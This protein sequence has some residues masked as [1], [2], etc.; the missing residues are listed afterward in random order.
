[1]FGTKLR[2]SVLVASAMLLAACG[3]GTKD[4]S[5]T[6]AAEAVDTTVPVIVE[7]VKI[8]A[9]F[10]LT[11]PFAV[12]GTSELEGAKAA[13]D[14][15]N[16]NGGILGRPIE[17]LIEDTGSDPQQAATAAAKL[18]KEGVVTIIGP[19]AG[20]VSLPIVP[21]AREANIPFISASGG[22]LP[23]V[24]AL[25]DLR[26]TFVCS[27]HTNKALASFFPYWLDKGFDTVALVGSKDPSFD[28]VVAFMEA[29]GK[30]VGIKIVVESFPRG[31]VDVTVNVVNA[32]SKGADVIF[33]P[34][35]G[36][37][38]ASVLLAAVSLG[39]EAEV[40]THGGN[41]SKGFI[42]LVGEAAFSKA[43]VSGFWSM[44]PNDA[45][46][47]NLDAI[48]RYR[49]DIEAAGQTFDSGSLAILGWDCIQMVV[50]AVEQAGGDTAKFRDA[51]ETL[52]YDGAAASWRNSADNHE[53]VEPGYAPLLSRA[54]GDWVFIRSGATR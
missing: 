48:A 40:S 39:V 2:I 50:A 15:I 21:V 25:E 30:E 43:V 33:T 5:P 35:V 41:V 52:S 22:F 23:L 11:G 38:G 14:A 46:Q 17:L 6:T 27:P 53:G 18:F 19:E 47:A 42:G 13:V 24:T 26:N 28:S 9:L 49:A 54:K 1:M 31:Q 20:P 45:P 4:S 16:A 32:M 10:S 36:A 8:G 7:P 51:L 12:A 34:S 3:G 44:A 29:K 37:S